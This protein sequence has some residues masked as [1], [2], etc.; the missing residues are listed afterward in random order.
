[1]KY[2]HQLQHQSQ[3]Q[4]QYQQYSENIFPTKSSV[5]AN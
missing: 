1:M 4:Q 5:A 3:H 2:Q